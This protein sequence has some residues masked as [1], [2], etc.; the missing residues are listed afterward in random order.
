MLDA[1][2]LAGSVFG[3]AIWVGG[4]T[5]LGVLFFGLELGPEQARKKITDQYSDLFIA[6][7]YHSI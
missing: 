1:A 6:A 3:E 4:E 7:M 5:S 2:M